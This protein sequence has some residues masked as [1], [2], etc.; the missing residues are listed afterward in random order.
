MKIARMMKLSFGIHR[1]PNIAHFADN[2][3]LV[4]T[5]QDLDD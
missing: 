2:D 3:V 4:I 5:G 1:Q